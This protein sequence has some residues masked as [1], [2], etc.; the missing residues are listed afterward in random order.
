MAGLAGNTYFGDVIDAGVR[1]FLYEKGYLHAKTIS[2]DSKIC[3]DR[4][5]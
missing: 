4:L 5:S 2:I 1:I 3:S